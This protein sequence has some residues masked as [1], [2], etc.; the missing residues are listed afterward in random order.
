MSPTKSQL[1]LGARRKK[2]VLL[3]APAFGG[4]PN[5]RGVVYKIAVMSPRKPNSARRTI[6]KVRLTYNGQRLFAKIPGVGSHFLQPHSIVFVR[7][8]GPKDCPGVNY[9]LVRGIYDFFKTE[10]YGRKQKRSKYGV[11]RYVKNS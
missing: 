9:Y 1:N 4:A 2:R 7:G 3:R 8:H 5:R 6:A 11:K 10:P